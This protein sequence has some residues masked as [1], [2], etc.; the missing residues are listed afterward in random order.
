[1]AHFTPIKI[2]LIVPE[3]AEDYE[4]YTTLDFFGKKDDDGLWPAGGLTSVGIRENNETRVISSGIA[5]L[6]HEVGH[7]AAALRHTNNRNDRD[8]YIVVYKGNIKE[9]MREY[10]DSYSHPNIKA[11][12]PYDY[13]SIMHYASFGNVVKNWECPILLKKG[14]PDTCDRAE[15]LPYTIPFEKKR[16]TTWNYTVMSVIY[17]HDDFTNEDVRPTDGRC[18]TEIVKRNLARYD[19]W[20]ATDKKEVRLPPSEAVCGDG[21]VDGVENC[22]WDDSDCLNDCSFSSTCV[23]NGRPCR[24]GDY[25]LLN[26]SVDDRQETQ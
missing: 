7:A 19:H 13:N 24:H 8:E 20:I 21:L 10:F 9:N 3:D 17:C 18:D 4:H 6:K 26:K 1:M 16:Y 11:I 15:L 2:K 25:T 5:A 22:D 14:A 12:G 23:F